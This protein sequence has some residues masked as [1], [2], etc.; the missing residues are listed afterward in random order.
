MCGATLIAA[1]WAL[2]S[3]P[4]L[5]KYW[6]VPFNVILSLRNSQKS[7]GAKSGEYGGCGTVA[8]FFPAMNLKGKRFETN[9]DIKA[10]TTDRLKLWKKEDFQAC[11][12]QWQK[13]KTSVYVLKES[14][15]KVISLKT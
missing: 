12:R 10:N 13:G 11:F 9:E 2:T 1:R 5:A 4:C 3:R 7:H 8:R 15:L 14:T 6:W